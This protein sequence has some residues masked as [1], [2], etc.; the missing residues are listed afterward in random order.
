MELHGIIQT[1]SARERNL[2]NIIS[3][4]SKPLAT[5]RAII[6]KSQTIQLLVLI[7]SLR[8]KVAID[9]ESFSVWRHLSIETGE[10]V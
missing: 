3:Y 8:Q 2:L 9:R 10:M 5:T 1:K 6:D 7:V 4:L